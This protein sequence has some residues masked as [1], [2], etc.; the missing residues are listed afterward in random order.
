M[1]S[2]FGRFILF[3]LAAFFVCEAVLLFSGTNTLGV[4]VNPIIFAIAVTCGLFFALIKKPTH[5]EESRRGAKAQPESAR[6]GMQ[7]LACTTQAEKDA[8]F[9]GSKRRK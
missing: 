6:L 1:I 9:S 5:S 2:F 8:Y 4:A 7:Y 3:S